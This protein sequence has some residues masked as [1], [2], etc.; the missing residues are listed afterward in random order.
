MT[1]PRSSHGASAATVCILYCFTE[2]RTEKLYFQKCSLQSNTAPSRTSYHPHTLLAHEIF[3]VPVLFPIIVPVY[4]YPTRSFCIQDD[5]AD[6]TCPDPVSPPFR[7]SD[8][9]QGC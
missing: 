4:H 8:P 5:L 9:L 3:A 2:D 1:L 7:P 6:A